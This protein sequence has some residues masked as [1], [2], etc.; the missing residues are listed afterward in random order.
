E[1]QGR[2]SA[3]VLRIIHEHLDEYLSVCQLGITFASIG[4][5]FVGEPAIA[6]LLI[7]ILGHIEAAHAVAITISYILIS[8]LHILLGELLPK[9]I[10]IRFA[11][12]SAL[13]TARPMVWSRY[14]LYLPLVVLNGSANLILKMLGL[15]GLPK[16]AAPSEAE[17]RIIL[18]K[19]QQEGMMPFRRLLL[20]ENLFDFGN[21]RVRDEMRGMDQITTLY[22]DCPWEE[23]RD[24]I[25]S[26][27]H[28]RYPLLEGNPPQCLGI[29]HIKDLVRGSTPWPEPTDLK[30]IAHK[31]YMTTPDMPLEQLLTEL[32]RRRIHM[33]LVQ[34]TK[35]RLCGLITMED[36]LEQLVGSIE[37]E[38]ETEAPLRLGDVLKENRVLLDLRATTALA[39]IRE[40]ILRCWKED[41]PVAGQA[42]IDAVSARERSLS[43]YLGEGLAVPHA[44]L[45]QVKIPVLFFA[46]SSEG[47]VFDPKKPE[48]KAAV[49]FL[50]LTPG[51]VP[52]L[53]I[54]LLARIANLR[55][56]VYVWDRLLRAKSPP[57]ALEAI[58]SGDELTT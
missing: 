26:T 43:T 23:N 46:R 21:V 55:E 24:K 15:Y 31:T 1:D 29:I 51:A 36:I 35:G 38:F 18:E 10:A 22:A 47:V 56:S 6:Q 57:E 34:D 7:P 20:F 19:S 13:F 40:I 14:I 42:V 16:E 54:R 45:D 58:R 5:G 9:S 27:V 49:L 33:A 53:Q 8:F 30:T 32:R 28:T 37:D 11:E 39:A 50:L 52:R 3:P 4:L 2:H 25:M 17:V 44:R 12:R 41:L 48:E